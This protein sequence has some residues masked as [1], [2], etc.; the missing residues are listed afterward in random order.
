MLLIFL[1]IHCSKKDTPDPAL[2]QTKWDFKSIINNATG[3]KT[4]IPSEIS[5]E[6]IEFVDSSGVIGVT[7]CANTC[8]G[9]YK[10]LNSDSIKITGFGCTTIAAMD[11]NCTNWERYLLNSLQTSYG[12]SLE[13]NSLIIKSSDKYNLVF[14]AQ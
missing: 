8:R 13:G 3:N 2:A 10:L 1:F 6:F 12:Y 5:S 4:N 14:N 7:T 9:Y 11:T